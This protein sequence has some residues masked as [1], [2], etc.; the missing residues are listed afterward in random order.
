M[1]F[2]ALRSSLER[3]VGA[4]SAACLCWTGSARWCSVTTEHHLN[5]GG[6]HGGQGS[7]N[8]TFLA[9][10]SSGKGP[11]ALAT[12]LKELHC[13]FIQPSWWDFHHCFTDLTLT[14]DRKQEFGLSRQL[15]CF[16]GQKNAQTGTQ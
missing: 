15:T 1:F 5:R 8:V 10:L 6:V 11:P 16:W 4:V 9:Q 14:L 13:C 2:S 12:A 7:G 3:S